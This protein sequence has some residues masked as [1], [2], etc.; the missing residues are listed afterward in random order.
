MAMSVG[1]RD[2]F[3]STFKA[4]DFIV[5]LFKLFEWHSQNEVGNIGILMYSCLVK[6]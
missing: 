3:V 4:A 1:K 6:I 5:F 2:Y